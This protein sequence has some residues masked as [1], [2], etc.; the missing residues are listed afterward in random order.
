MELE[1]S[2][3]AGD[4]QVESPS[5]FVGSIAGKLGA[6]ARAATIFGDPVERDGVTVIPVARA[7]WGFGGGVGR[8]KDE[9]GAGGGRGRASQS[10]R[11]HRVEKW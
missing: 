8:K 2:N 1:A 11:I 5:K 7:G 4:A 10:R 6:T 9:N 3:S